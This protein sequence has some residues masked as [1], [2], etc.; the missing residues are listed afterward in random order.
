MSIFYCFALLLFKQK[1]DIQVLQAAQDVPQ[2]AAAATFV[3]ANSSRIIDKQQW[4]ANCVI[5]VYER[6]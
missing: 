6:L 5:N 1:Y 3:H 2:L 4:N